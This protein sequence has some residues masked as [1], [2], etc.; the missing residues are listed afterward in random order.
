[1]QIQSIQIENFREFRDVVT[2]RPVYSEAKNVTLIRGNGSDEVDTLY[3]A[4]RWCFWGEDALDCGNCFFLN[5][6][7]AD[8]LANDERQNVQVEMRLFHQGTT[9]HIL[10]TLECIRKGN[11]ILTAPASVV[12]ISCGGENGKGQE[13]SPATTTQ[14][15]DEFCQCALVRMIRGVSGRN[16]RAQLQSGQVLLFVTAAELESVGE[17]KVHVWAQ[18][19]YERVGKIYSL[20]KSVRYDVDPAWSDGPVPTGRAWG[21]LEGLPRFSLPGRPALEKLF[22]DHVV[23][24]VRTPSQYRRL[25]VDF[26]GAIILHG[27][28]GSGKTYAVEQLGEFLGWPRYYIDNAAV[29]SIYMHE[30]GIKINRVFDQA[31]LNAPSIVVIDEM[32][33]F[34]SHR[35]SGPQ[36]EAHHTEEVSEFLRRIPEAIQNHV[37]VIGMTNRLDDIDPAFLRRGRFDH[38]IEVEM[39]TQEETAA[40]LGPLLS[41]LPTAEDVDPLSLSAAL[42]GRPM[43]DLVFVVKEAG[44]LSAKAGEETIGQSALWEA[45]YTLPRIGG[46]PYTIGFTA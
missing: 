12:T 16:L 20:R 46:T 31:A 8:Q 1:M 41:K 24:I 43:S 17:D 2:L 11:L 27:A 33:A 26:P 14:F 36:D 3:Q 34:L 9:Y 18:D 4:C 42:A 13:L 39:P 45:F 10:R 29:G 22:N 44:R 5:G 15:L 7:L 28:P 19:I 38:I 21:E 32:D 40:A 35:R 25:G 30:T 37:L 23:D 6:N